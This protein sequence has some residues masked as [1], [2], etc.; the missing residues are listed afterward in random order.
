MQVGAEIT[1]QAMAA[2]PVQLRPRRQVRVDDRQMTAVAV[3]VVI[4]VVMAMP[5]APVVAFVTAAHPA[6]SRVST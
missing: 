6:L 2:V 3:V 4:V 5:A 1:A